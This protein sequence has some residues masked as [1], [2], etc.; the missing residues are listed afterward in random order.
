LLA[1]ALIFAGCSGE[2]DSGQ[3]MSPGMDTGVGRSMAKLDASPDLSPDRAGNATREAGVDAPAVD[4]AFDGSGEAGDAPNLVPT[5]TVEVDLQSLV[6][7]RDGGVTDPLIVPSTYGPSPFVT[8][9]VVSSSGDLKLD[10]V[11]SVSAA[12]YDPLVTTPISTTKLARSDSRVT[13]ESNTMRFI[14][15]GV[16]LDLSKLLSASYTVVFTATTV[17]GATGQTKVTLSVDA[18]PSMTVKLPA[19]GGFYKGS[20]PIEVQA[21]QNKF[22]I[23]QVTMALGQGEAVPLTSIGSGSYKGMI[24]FAAYTPPLEGPQLVTFRAR[25]ENGTEAVVLRKFVS[26][27]IGPTISATVPSIGAKIGN[28]IS[29]SA[30]VDDLAGVDATSVIAIVG[31]GDQNFEVTLVAAEGSKIYSSLFDCTKLPSY[32]LYPTISFRAR[33]RLGNESNTSY[34]LSLDNEPPLMDLDPPSISISKQDGDKVVCSWL[35]DPV[36]PD[37][38]DDGDVVPQLFDVR[39]RIED[40]GNKPLTGFADFVPIGGIDNGKVKLYVVA[41]PTRPLVVDSSDPPDGYCDD[42]NPE[43]VPTTRPQTDVDAQV[44]DMV[45]LGP[46]GTPDY[47]PGPADC[48][49]KSGDPPAA[50]CDTTVNLSKAV[51][52]GG[53]SHSDRLT[54]TL[55]YN[56][57]NEPAIYTLGPVVNDKLQCAGRQFDSSNNLKNGWA[58]LAVK[59]SD[60]LGNSQVS[61]PIRVCVMANATDKACEGPMPDCTGTL[62]MG[63]A[64][65]GRPLV[66][67]TR[68]CKP[69]TNK[70]AFIHL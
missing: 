64:D 54:F 69:W 20:A 36:G 53:K 67:G 30:T 65:G 31:N 66:D 15:S 42:I 39:A 61:R 68:P 2:T 55:S 56:V 59:A 32:A 63:A 6:P 24:D 27:N 47:S 37:A 33:D 12:I 58:C 25:N 57:Q 44:L 29:I 11:S 49:S 17:G 35:F 10:T 5:V 41:N 28:V 70:A 3:G 52:Y 48:Y 19:E 26:D 22:A 7:A 13:P 34:M 43:L 45:P 8:V 50:I 51:V 23:A 40:R 62:V 38:V 9:T 4:A 1:V 14:F 18:G 46:Q 60:T 16:P 21:T